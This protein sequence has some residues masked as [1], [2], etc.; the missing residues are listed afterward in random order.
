MTADDYYVTVCADCLRASCWH[1]EE[2]CSEA[3]WAG[4]TTLLASHLRTLGLER[5]DN[6]SRMTLM[7]VCG[8]VTEVKR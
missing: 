5:P 2:F 4:E 8:S 6:Y 1:A 3:Y 7:D